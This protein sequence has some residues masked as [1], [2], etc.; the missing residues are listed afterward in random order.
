MHL[1]VLLPDFCACSA[2]TF[3]PLVDC[4]LRDTR[5][6]DPDCDLDGDLSARGDDSSSSSLGDGDTFGRLISG[7]GLTDGDTACVGG[8]TPI[9]GG[10]VGTGGGDICGL[11]DC[12]LVFPCL[13]VFS[14]FLGSC[15]FVLCFLFD[16]GL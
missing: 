15:F 12:A 8:E 10:A 6:G 14:G 5:G 7:D 11:I 4:G 9:G 2:V 16:S 1:R 3:L 13:L